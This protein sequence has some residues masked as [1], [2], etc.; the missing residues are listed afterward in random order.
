MGCE[1]ETTHERDHIFVISF[2]LGDSGTLC[3]VQQETSS[4]IKILSKAANDWK[5]ATV[6]TMEA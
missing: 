6:W 4:L 2:H 1:N 5:E 3:L